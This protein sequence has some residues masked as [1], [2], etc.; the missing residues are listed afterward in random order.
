MTLLNIWQYHYAEDFAAGVKLLV[1][2]DGLKYLTKQTATRLKML[3][4]SG[5]SVDA[6]NRGKLESALNKVLIVDSIEITTSKDPSYGPP[7]WLT[8]GNPAF[9]AFKAFNEAIDEHVESNPPNT[10]TSPLAKELHKEHAHFHA[11]M[12][13]ADTDAERALQAEKVLEINRQLDAEYDRLRAGNQPDIPESSKAARSDGKT[14]A[15]QLRQLHSLRTRVSK[16]KNK[17][18]PKANGPR[19]AELEKELEIKLADIKRIEND[20]A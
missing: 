6:Y 20:L 7:I 12:V 10:L 4:A 8:P 5:G 16:L 2:H 11:L 19:L 15:D 1:D 13:S 18:I 9:A 3:A 17:L 14:E